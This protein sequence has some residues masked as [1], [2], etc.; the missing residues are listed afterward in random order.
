MKPA[1]GASG[2]RLVILAL[3]VLV[4]AGCSSTRMAYR[5]ADW[6]VVW[7]VED[8]VTLTDAQS[9]RLQEDF[10]TFQ[11]WHCSEELPR[12]SR[13]LADLEQ[14]VT[15]GRTSPAEIRQRQQQLF[16]AVDRLLVR[17][18]PIASNLLRDLSPAQVAELE[19]N[20]A[21]NQREKQQEYLNPDPGVVL[22]NRE[23]R[24]RERAERW[25]GELNS[26]QRGLIA[27]WNEARGN[28]TRIWLEGR[29]RWQ[30]ALL[31]TL[32]LRDND[33][34]EARMTALIQ[35]SADFR[36]AEYQAMMTESRESL[37]PLVSGLLESASQSQRQ[38]LLQ[39]LAE[40]R[41]DLEALSC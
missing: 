7:W 20:M 25:L 3:V 8:Y 26:R 15:A 16:A 14:D 29:Q 11:Q 34:F 13:W 28:Q 22:E 38:H 32:L 39:E 27:E 19:A 18:T 21:S 37:A 41:R 23:S 4:I 12:Y 6:G 40:L 36:G 5:Y 35:D 10:R 1:P 30:A 33:A 31:E 9:A 2:L 17:A 24:T